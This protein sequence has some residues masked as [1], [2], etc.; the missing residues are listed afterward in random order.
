M[1]RGRVFLQYWLPV[2]VWM[3]IIFTA[4]GDSDSAQRSSRVIEPV[5][6]WLFP[7]LSDDTVHLIV[8]LVRKC[9]HL[10]EYAVLALLFWRALRKPVRDDPRPWKWSEAGWAMLFV[11]AYGIS[12]E[13]HQ[14]LI[15][16]RQGRLHDVAIDTAGA[17][18]GLFTLWLLGRWPHGKRV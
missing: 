7:H 10:M 17:A 11:A 15:P 3:G 18:V 1:S 4:S 13:L 14:A 9:A 16:S 12:D 8:F 2:A 5:V 6:R